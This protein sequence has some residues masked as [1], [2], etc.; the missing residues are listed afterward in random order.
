MVVGYWNEIVPG[1]V[2]CDIVTPK[3]CR[4]HPRGKI[5]S[6]GLYEST[7]KLLFKIESLVSPISYVESNNK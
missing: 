7:S 5:T 6:H 1:S 4:I 2:Y 3:L